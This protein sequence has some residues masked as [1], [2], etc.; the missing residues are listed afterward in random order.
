MAILNCYTLFSCSAIHWLSCTLCLFSHKLTN[1]FSF[2]CQRKISCVD[3][4]TG[5][6]F[7]N[8]YTIRRIA[9]TSVFKIKW[10]SQW[11]QT[12][13]KGGEYKQRLVDEITTRHIVLFH[14]NTWSTEA[15]V[16]KIGKNVGIFSGMCWKWV[17]L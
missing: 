14:I 1:I 3:F 12:D 6:P 15:K 9:D 16:L 4:K 7:D 2:F 11:A 13:K 17:K 8:N 10:T 5:L